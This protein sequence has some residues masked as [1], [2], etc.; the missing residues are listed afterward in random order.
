M[1]LE[2]DDPWGWVREDSSDGSCCL[3]F[4]ICYRVV[5]VDEDLGIVSEVQDS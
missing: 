5:P 2:E 1:E 4:E 3:G